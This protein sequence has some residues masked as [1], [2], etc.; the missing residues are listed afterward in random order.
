MGTGTL[1]PVFGFIFLCVAM[2]TAAVSLVTP[3][4]CFEK[5]KM[6][7]PG[8][9]ELSH[10]LGSQSPNQVCKGQHILLCRLQCSQWD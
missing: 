1:N 7:R 6:P 5:T 2:R 9:T 10:H 8:D 3:A 4:S